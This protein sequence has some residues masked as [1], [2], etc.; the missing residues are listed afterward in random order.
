MVSHSFVLASPSTRTAERKRSG[1]GK[2]PV[3]SEEVT[4]SEG[5]WGTG[6]LPAMP[7][8]IVLL[9]RPAGLAT[10]S[11]GRPRAA[12]VARP[13]GLVLTPQLAL[14]QAP[15]HCPLQAELIIEDGCINVE[16]LNQNSGLE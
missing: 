15:V 2:G 16:F 13:R 11:P 1:Y 7:G 12:D 9:R 14:Q 3:I 10:A 6:G 8:G 4:H 5:L